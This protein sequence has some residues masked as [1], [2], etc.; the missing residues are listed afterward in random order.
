MAIPPL[1]PQESDEAKIEAFLKAKPIVAVS[2]DSKKRREWSP[3]ARAAAGERMRVRQSAGMMKRPGAEVRERKTIKDDFK[4][5][6]IK[7]GKPIIEESEASPVNSE[8]LPEELGSCAIA[9]AP[10]SSPADR[11]QPTLLS[12]GDW[13]DIHELLASGTSRER[14]AGDYD[15]P[16]VVLDEFID[17]NLAEAKERR[18]A[19]DAGSGEA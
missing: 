1:A 3:E 13:P 6:I 14:I 10:I 2:S 4:P 11:W 7:R 5:V 19:K 8:R 15:V 12:S 16:L 18:A 17:Q 9:T